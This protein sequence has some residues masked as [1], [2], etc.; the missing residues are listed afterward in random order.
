MQTKFWQ[1]LHFK[2][3]IFLSLIFTVI[4]IFSY[5]IG[6]NFYKN[7]KDSAVSIACSNITD[8][9]KIVSENMTSM[10]E[11]SVMLFTQKIFYEQLAYLESRDELRGVKDPSKIID[12][13]IK[14]KDYQKIFEIKPLTKY[15]YVTVSVADSDKLILVVHNKKDIIGRN[16]FELVKNLSEEDRRKQQ[17]EKFISHWVNRESGGIYYEQTSTFKDSSIPDDYKTKYAYQYWGKFNGV[18]VVVEVTSYIK[19]FTKVTGAVEKK[20][21]DTISDISIHTARVFDENFKFYIYAVIAVVVLIIASMIILG[22]SFIIRP[23]NKIICGLKKFSDGKFTE[24][25]PELPPGEFSLISDVANDMAQKLA[26]TMNNLEKINSELEL[27]VTERTSEL[28][29]SKKIIEIEKE[30]SETLIKNILPAKIAAQLMDNPDQTIAREHAM[31]TIIFS[32]FKGFTTMSETTTPI[33]LVRE[34]N[35]I[36]AY[37]D[38][39]CEKYNIEKIKTIGDAYMAAGGIPESNETNP[40]D[41]VEMA[42]AMRDYILERRNDS[43]NLPLEIRIGIHSGPVIAGVIGKKRFIYDI[44]GD[45]VNIASRMESNGAPGKVNISESTYKLVKDKY[46]CEARGEIM[47][48]GKGNMMTYFVE[49]QK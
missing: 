10:N 24:R 43:Q 6:E 26:E 25:M 12:F 46:A 23:V 7:L 31:A 14:N 27:K 22:N 40:Y 20:H 41:A 35:E 2:I 44:W 19:E 21:N 8:V 16:I 3:I 4:C 1:T 15:S 29:E 32:D 28:L 37:F 33:K 48:K 30:K 5:C 9:K 47:I 42:L 38:S 13:C 45:S 18:D 49:R 36:F 34:L 11:N 17:T 39:L